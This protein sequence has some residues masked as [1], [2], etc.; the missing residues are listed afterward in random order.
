MTLPSRPVAYLCLGLSMAL[1]GSYVALSKPL[2]AI[3]PV[4]LLA[5]LRFGIGVVAMLGWLKRPTGEAP[6]SG[7]TKVLLFFESFFG[8]FLFTLCMISGVAMTSAVTA[9]VTMAAIPAAVAVMSWLFLRE[10]VGLRT[11][12]AIVL[13]VLGISLNALSKSGSASTEGSQAVLGQLLLVAAVLCEAAY[14]V[15]GKKLTAS[16]SPK[17][18][19]ALIN[20]WGFALST[21][22]GLYLALQ[23]DFAQVALP[24]WGLLLFY[25]LA[26]CVW[27]VWLWMTGLRVI[28]ASQA[29]IFT[30]LLPIS[31]ALVG[32]ALGERIS[33]MQF[34]AF[35]I[36]L[37]SV[38]IA[39]WPESRKNI[40]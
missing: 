13:A 31:A 29:G 8:N 20:L 4:M 12:G 22:M 30:V 40:G 27:T 18:I 21:P 5:W 33:G 10:V 19:T 9:G 38:L 32:M 14:A 25:A 36:A 28:A 23:F 2:A 34:L 16:V 26:A 15:I 6:L 1:V 35:G 39:T 3:F 24:S 37:A 7:Q 11:W 17:R